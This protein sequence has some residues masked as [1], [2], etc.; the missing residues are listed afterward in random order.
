MIIEAAV[1]IVNDD[2]QRL[3]PLSRIADERVIDVE[4]KV[5]AA[6]DVGGRMIVVGHNDTGLLTK[7]GSIQQTLGKV[8]SAACW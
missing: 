5:L 3:I 2:E 8:P 7:S 4:N 6:A 1:L